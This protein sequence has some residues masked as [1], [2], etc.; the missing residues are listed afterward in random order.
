MWESRLGSQL[1]GG[2]KSK[3]NK[4]CFRAK[5]TVT[6]ALCGF[7]SDSNSGLATLNLCRTAGKQKSSNLHPCTAKTHECVIHCSACLAISWLSLHAYLSADWVPIFYK[8]K[9]AVQHKPY[10]PN[11]HLVACCLKNTG[12]KISP[13]DLALS[14]FLEPFWH[15]L[16]KCLSRQWRVSQ[17]WGGRP[18]ALAKRRSSWAHS[19]GF[20]T[21]VEDENS[22]NVQEDRR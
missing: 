14:R 12:L 17:Y 4:V 7:Q 5:V 21:S 10:T 2:Q 1:W 18:G 19:S 16:A 9:Y 6:A 15:T 22:Q 13:S 8:P 11:T 3:V 20:T